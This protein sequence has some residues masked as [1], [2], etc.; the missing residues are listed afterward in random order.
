MMEFLTFCWDNAW[1]VVILL[2][3][4]ASGGGILCWILASMFANGRIADMFADLDNPANVIR[5]M[6][7]R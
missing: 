5:R 1:R 3:I 7:R 2:F 4:G 6:R